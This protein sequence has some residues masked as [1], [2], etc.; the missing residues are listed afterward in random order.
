M[1][2]VG[3]LPLG[4]GTGPAAT[5]AALGTTNL[6]AATAAGIVVSSATVLAVLIYA[7]VIWVWRA[8]LP[9][10]VPA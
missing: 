7:G 2:A 10:P 4:I 9:E 6:V 1:G 5:V 8:R 3:L